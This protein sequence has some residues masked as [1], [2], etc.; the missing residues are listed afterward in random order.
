[1]K[2]IIIALL[3]IFCTSS[4]FAQMEIFFFGGNN[5]TIDSNTTFAADFNNGASG[6][7]T[8]VGFGL[9][10]EVAPFS[11]RNIAPQRDVVSVSMKLANSA[12]YEWR[13]Y[14]DVTDINERDGNISSGV[15]MPSMYGGRFQDQATSIWFNTFIAQLEYNQYWMRI[16]GLEPEL[17]VSQSSIKSVFDGI[18][19]NR[20]DVANNPFPLPLFRGDG[21]HYNGNGGVV[22]LLSRD[23]VHLNRREVEIAGNLSFGMNTDTIDAVFKIG[24][25]KKAEEN[26]TNAWALGADLYWKPDLSQRINLSVLSAVNYGTVRDHNNINIKDPMADFEKLKENPVA[27]GLGYDYRF[28]LPRRMVLRPYAGFDLLMET[29]TGDYNYELGGGFQ[30]Y[31]RGTSASN[32][33]NDKIGGVNLG[34][35]AIPAALFIGINSDKNGLMNAVISFNED[36]KNSPLKNVGGYLLAEFMNITGKEYTVIYKHEGNAY[37]PVTFN[38][39]MFAGMAQIEYLIS[40]KI[41]PY[42]F[43]MFIPADMRG[44]LVTD[45]PEYKKNRT[46]L[47]S[48]VGVVFSPIQFFSVDIW[49]ERTDVRVIRDWVLD[50]GVFSMTFAMRNYL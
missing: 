4:V 7:Y 25:W 46:S 15:V 37:H 27:L 1:M 36:P 23:I 28:D 16:A 33:R 8:E 39:L 19:A 20:T 12:F 26:E 31:F 6:L 43:G 29:N 44:V 42:V 34:D 50:N 11:D 5:L 38:E 17:T 22:G 21:N 47:T 40:G 14:D 18:I 48:K 49:Y 32:K 2:K 9:W 10:F 41:M 45:A 35:V 3:F 24:S 13:G 30:W